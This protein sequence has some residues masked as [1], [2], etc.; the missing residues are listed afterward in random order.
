[1]FSQDQVDQVG[2]QG[3]NV[4]L[5]TRLIFLPF[6]MVPDILSPVDGTGCFLYKIKL[7]AMAG[8]FFDPCRFGKENI[9]LARGPVTAAR[10]H[11]ATAPTVLSDFSAS[12][13]P[14]LSRPPSHEL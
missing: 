3:Q 12:K 1:M 11:L 8:I 6:F 13:Y 5:C 9:T 2:L 7:T 14:S 4:L 10:D